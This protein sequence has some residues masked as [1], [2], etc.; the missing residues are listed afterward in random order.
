MDWERQSLNCRFVATMNCL[1]PA[2][3]PFV[4]PPRQNGF[5]TSFSQQ[6]RIHLSLRF[7]EGA[8]RS[9][10]GTVGSAIRFF[11]LLSKESNLRSEWLSDILL[12]TGP[13]SFVSPLLRRCL[14]QPFWHGWQRH[15]LLSPSEQRV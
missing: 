2:Y 10:S 11:H 1:S 9:H 15:P 8:F 4:Q 7:F 6:V 3:R 14:P 12:A 5:P 13:H